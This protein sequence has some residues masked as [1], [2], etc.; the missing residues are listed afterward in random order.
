M[1]TKGGLPVGKK[2]NT[3]RKKEQRDVITCIVSSWK[4]V[5]SSTESGLIHYLHQ[6]HG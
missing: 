4:P 2:L 6:W 5:A 3:A 1:Q